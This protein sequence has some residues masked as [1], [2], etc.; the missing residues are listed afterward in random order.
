MWSVGFFDGFRAMQRY[1]QRTGF[2][3]GALALN[4]PQWSNSDHLAAVI[5]PTLAEGPVTM[6]EALSVPPVSRA[7]QLY[8]SV[9]AT[10]PLE[11]DG[12]EDALWLRRTAG[13]LTPGHRTASTVQDLIFYGDSL[14][15]ADGDTYGHV[16]RHLWNIDPDGNIVDSDSQVQNDVIYFPS[17]LP[18]GFLSFGADS[19]RHYHGI[20]RG[21]LQRSDNPT[22]IT[23]LKVTDPTEV[24]PDELKAAQDSYAT[25]R[26]S[27]NGAITITPAGVDLI[28][29]N[30]GSDAASMLTE[31]RNA[32]RLD[33]AN[34]LNINAAMLDGNSGTS[35]TYSN[36]LQ[37]A[38]EFL[39]LSLST[40]LTPI[41]DRLSQPDV[42]DSPVR[43]DT[44]R[45]DTYTNAVG[46]VGTAVPQ[47]NTP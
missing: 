15:A 45:F 28:M 19:I 3:D 9:A 39:T 26:R 35:D 4:V 44:S 30:V 2:Q 10:F 24:D 7:V 1:N 13:A 8:S 41:E 29:H 27:K 47:E 25:A 20:L 43:F 46:N 21:I 5:L 40:W 18:Q 17:L 36:T 14:W 6:A 33:M 11:T 16:P 31:A 22:P 32:V 42:M 23:E 12:G 38:N 37:N 34:F